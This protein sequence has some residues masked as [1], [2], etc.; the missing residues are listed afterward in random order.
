MLKIKYI[1]FLLLVAAVILE[2]FNIFLS[3][4]IAGSSIEVS[5]LSQ[6]IE[7]IEGKN[8]SL[9]TELLSY[10]SF[11]NIASRAASLGFVENKDTAIM[12]NAPLKVA[13][14]R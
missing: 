8:T 7:E 14:G 13:L 2:G 1:P 12:I 5:L 9:K 3:N 4:S 11:E 10:S 6:K